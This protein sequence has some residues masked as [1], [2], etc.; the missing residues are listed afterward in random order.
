MSRPTT[1]DPEEFCET[2]YRFLNEVISELNR[3]EHGYTP[4]ERLTPVEAD[5]YRAA[6]FHFFV[7][8]EGLDWAYAHLEDE[9]EPTARALDRLG[10]TEAAGSLRECMV[11]NGEE[12]ERERDEW[13]E[14]RRRKATEA[15]FK[16]VRRAE[17]Q[18][19]NDEKPVLRALMAYLD[20]RY[21]WA[22]TG[23]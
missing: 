3:R 17:A 5:A 4:L 14:E 20:E 7:K 9:N 16:D 11:C 6:Q 2:V 18:I 1:E 19:D 15:Y 8:H 23:R 10:A 13:S 12:N 21:P 22:P